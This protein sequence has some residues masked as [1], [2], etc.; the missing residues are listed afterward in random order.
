MRSA[1]WKYGSPSGAM[2]VYGYG[3]PTGGVPIYGYGTQ[4]GAVPIYGY[5]YGQPVV[6]APVMAPAQHA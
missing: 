4:S 2:P 1:C 6:Q 5:T 3:T